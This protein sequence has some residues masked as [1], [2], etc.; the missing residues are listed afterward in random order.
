M[1]R[2]GPI[3]DDPITYDLGPQRSWE[4]VEGPARQV[5]DIREL[6]EK[7]WDA[8]QQLPQS[9]VVRVPL[10]DNSLMQQLIT[11]IGAMLEAGFKIEIWLQGDLVPNDGTGTAE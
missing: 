3:D 6:V 11:G 4:I 8:V 5:I 9:L 10:G 2:S 1:S 7:P